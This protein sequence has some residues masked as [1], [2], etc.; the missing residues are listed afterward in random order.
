MRW[1]L[2]LWIFVLSAVAFLDRV[3]I[4]IA[5]SS[6]AAE[7][8]LTDVRLGYVFSSFLVGYA[9]CQAPGGRLA[10]RFG[11]RRV[12][13]LAV[14]WWGLFTALTASVPAG[15]AGALILLI[16]IRVL[17]GAGEAVIFPA[18]NQFVSKWIPTTERGLANGLIFAGVGA[19]SCA[20]PP[21]VTYIM[22]HHGWRA[23]FWISAVLGVV[24]GAVWFLLARDTPERHP[25]VS[26]RELAHIKAGLTVELAP[27]RQPDRQLP[28][29]V[30]LKSKEVLAMG[31][32][33]FTYGYVAWIFFSWFFIYLAR[34][35]GLNLKAS[36]AFATLPFLAMAIGSTA[37][38]A[39][40][41]AL[42]RRL[43]K[44]SGRCIFSL[45]VMLLAAAFLVYGA[46]I[47]SARLASVVLA[48]GAGSLYLSQ[49]SYW[50]VSADIAG[51]SSG[52]VSGLM[53]MG[54]QFGGAVTA[55]LTPAIAG[56]YGWTASFVVAAVLCTLGGFAWLVVS[57]ERSLGAQLNP[58]DAP[59]PLPE[60]TGAR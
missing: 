53:N 50:S 55:S 29:G 6:I 28:W 49:S 40:S 56:A 14:L 27:A 35:R 39:I 11:P 24:A 9:F 7:Y 22:I 4:S 8:H 5:G 47:H 15:L 10:D 21:L 45:A 25:W 23:S 20:T 17:L 52:T 2:I 19:G 51:N 16:S 43:G 13:A 31:L 33:Y 18:S 38:G 42:T 30:I 57:P 54:G 1:L 37:G 36:A 48:G 58:E 12:I 26:A 34:V 46:H 3:N 59:F 60:R 32:S 41:D 44:R